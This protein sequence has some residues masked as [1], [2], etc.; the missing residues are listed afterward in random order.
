MPVFLWYAS[1]AYNARK[2]LIGKDVEPWIL[3][4]LRI[5]SI[6]SFIGAFVQISDFLRIYPAVGVADIGN[7]ISL[8]IFYVQSSI[9]VACSV[10]QYFAWV[11]PSKLK[12]YFNRNY[13]KSNDSERI[14]NLTEDEILKQMREA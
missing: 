5:L 3:T 9:A 1:E 8:T 6:S 2:K 4:R 14:N 11:M 12:S 10:F 7:S 13:I